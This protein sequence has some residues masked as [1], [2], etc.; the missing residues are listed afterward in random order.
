MRDYESHALSDLIQSVMA[1]IKKYC[2]TLITSNPCRTS[3]CCCICWSICAHNFQ[4]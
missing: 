1:N 4:T 3:G 2:A